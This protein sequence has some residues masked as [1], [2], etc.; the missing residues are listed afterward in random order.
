MT[1][2][3]ET[4]QAQQPHIRRFRTFRSV[5]ALILREMASRYGRSPGG[6][7]WAIL[8]PA[9]GIA[10]LTIVFGLILRSPP[11]GTNFPLFYASGI[12]PFFFFNGISGQ[13]AASLQYS[14]ALLNYP[15]MT[16]MDA[17]I[18]RFL[19]NALT[20]SLIMVILIAAIIYA[21]NLNLIIDWPALFL[22]TA[23]LCAIT[24]AVGTLNCFLFAMFPIWQ[25]IW[26][27]ITRPLLILSGVLFIPENLPQQMREYFLYNPLAHVISQFRHGFY[28]IYDAPYISPVYVFT[29]SMIVGGFGVLLLLR[30]YKDI[31]LK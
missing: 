17:I 8:E 18:A 25:N 23:M 27:V 19:L 13:I 28:A 10:I 31:M 22:A 2:T 11:L 15:V 12:I 26:S 7:L 30:N 1:P 3:T 5:T 16:F 14:R 21:Y 20:Q 24:I 6:Y 4:P 9:A 29:V